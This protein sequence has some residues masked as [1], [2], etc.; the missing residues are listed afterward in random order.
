MT[1]H[2]TFSTNKEAPT[3][4]DTTAYAKFY[5]KHNFKEIFESY[6][7]WGPLKIE[8][9]GYL[10]PAGRTFTAESMYYLNIKGGV[11]PEHEKAPRDH[12]EL[13]C[14][15]FDLPIKPRKKNK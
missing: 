15:I 2:L 12:L 10:S 9:Y 6:E 1:H 13:L 7:S 4:D 3:E 8:I 5:R 14:K 11:R